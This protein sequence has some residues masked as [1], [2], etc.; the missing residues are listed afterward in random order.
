MA[1]VHLAP[2]DIEEVLL[3]AL[4]EALLAKCANHEHRPHDVAEHLNRVISSLKRAI[5]KEGT[6]GDAT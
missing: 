4:R 1:D 5:A 3:T 2:M 6:A